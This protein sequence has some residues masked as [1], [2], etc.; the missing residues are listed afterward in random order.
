M[1]V[2]VE[3]ADRNR[4]RLVTNL[5]DLNTTIFGADL[6]YK[7]KGFSLFAEYYNRK[8]KPE[9]VSGTSSAT[10]GPAAQSGGAFH[11]NGY[12]VQAGYFLKKDKIEIAARFAGYDPSDRTPSNNRRE[13]G[14]VLNYFILKHALKVVADF[15]AL[16]CSDALKGRDPDE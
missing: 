2:G 12:N 14:G 7:Y 6:M 4:R 5:T 13:T 3:V 10:S 15:R 8:R 1:P 9:A 11:S 16:L